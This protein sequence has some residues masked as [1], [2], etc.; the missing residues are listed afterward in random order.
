MAANIPP[1]PNNVFLAEQE[2]YDRVVRLL[3]KD[4]L[5]EKIDRIPYEL[6][7]L[8]GKELEDERIAAYRDRAII[9]Y[10][11]IAALGF[12]VEDDKDE[13][14]SLASYAEEALKRTPKDLQ[15]PV[16]TFI[17]AACHECPPAQYYV[18]DACQRC[19]ARYCAQACAKKALTHIDGKAH[20]D[21]TKCVRCGKC[22]AAC[23]YNAIIFRPIPCI[24]ACPVKVIT[25]E[26]DGHN[27]FDWDKCIHC[28]SCR[29]S[30]PFGAIMPR[31]HIFDVV[32]AIKDKSQKV[33]AMLAPAVVGHLA[34]KVEI[35]AIMDALKKC[36]FF[37]VLEVSLG[38]DETAILEAE[39]FKERMEEAAHDPKHRQWMATSCC[40]AWV[41]CV[42]RHIPEIEDAISTTRSPMH[43]TSLMA[44][45]RW[46]GCTTV[47]VGPCNAKLAETIDDADVD[48]CINFYDMYSIIRGN[49]VTIDLKITS[50][51]PEAEQEPENF[52]PHIEGRAFPVIGNVAA[53]VA[54]F[55]GDPAKQEHPIRPIAVN[56][57]N[58]DAIKKIKTFNKVNPPGNIIE[59]MCCQN[60]CIA[61]PGAPVGPQMA[62]ARIKMI[63]KKSKIHPQGTA[64]VPFN[65]VIITGDHLVDPANPKSLVP[66]VHPPHYGAI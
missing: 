26:A 55:L 50:F 48:L 44:K 19:N 52:K 1:A 64:G 7:P 33:V 6:R 11:V 18:T 31:S 54:S 60:G 34:M 9:R 16:L 5:L 58:P 25:R 36:G 39:E 29:R 3:V 8:T 23:P 37:E 66:P 4:E 17:E 21:T 65:P 56:G 20:I 46:P 53:A 13:F 45:K 30:C 49:D 35:P 2:I 22:F 14:R 40:P 47:F 51:P 57:L 24:K 12:R 27:K 38:G 28:G 63:A 32:K 10:R 15:K 59:V 41:A 61:G 62:G 43:Y 42:H